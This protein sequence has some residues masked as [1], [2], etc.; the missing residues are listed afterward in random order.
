MMGLGRLVVTLKSKI[1]RSLKMKKPYDKVEK[2]ESMR[3]EI[4]SRKARKLIEETLKIADSPRSKTFAFWSCLIIPQKIQ[5]F[6]SILFFIRSFNETIVF[7][8][9]YVLHFFNSFISL[10]NIH[11]EPMYQ[12]PWIYLLWIW[13]WNMD[14]VMNKCE[15][16]WLY[17]KS[18]SF[19]LL[20]SSNYDQKYFPLSVGLI[21]QFGLSQ[22]KILQMNLKLLQCTKYKVCWVTNVFFILCVFTQLFWLSEWEMIA[23]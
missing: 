23:N 2:S 17:I 14:I 3:M 6:I 1:I 18:V 10:K 12:V 9:N 5:C 8:F 13:F 20:F 19:F 16:F 4:R 15:F 22:I 11:Q 21:F 7:I